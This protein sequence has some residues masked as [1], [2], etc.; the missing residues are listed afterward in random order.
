MSD[1][2][3]IA[4]TRMW[5]AVNLDFSKK[6]K[7][8]ID[9]L[10]DWAQLTSESPFSL[11]TN[12]LKGSLAKNNARSAKVAPNQLNWI[13]R[14][15]FSKA[16]LKISDRGGRVALEANEFDVSKIR[17]IKRNQTMLTELEKYRNHGNQKGLNYNEF[18][19]YTAATQLSQIFCKSLGS[20]FSKSSPSTID[21]HALNL[22]ISL[23]TLSPEAIAS[24]LQELVTLRYHG[25]YLF[26][27]LL[28]EIGQPPILKELDDFTGLCYK[29]LGELAG[30]IGHNKDYPVESLHELTSILDYGSFGR[31]LKIPPR[32]PDI[33]NILNVRNKNI[34]KGSKEYAILENLT[35]DIFNDVFANSKGITGDL[36]PAGMNETEESIQ[37]FDLAEKLA[38][39]LQDYLNDY[40][41]AVGRSQ[42]LRITTTD[43]KLQAELDDLVKVATEH[44]TSIRKAESLTKLIHCLIESPRIINEKNLD[45]AEGFDAEFMMKAQLETFEYQIMKDKSQKL[46][47]ALQP[48]SEDI[49]EIHEMLKEAISLMASASDAEGVLSRQ[50]SDSNSRYTSAQEGKQILAAINVAKSNLESSFTKILKNISKGN[51][52]SLKSVA[53]KINAIINE[54]RNTIDEKNADSIVTHSGANAALM[55]GL[56]QGGEQII[57][58]AMAKILNTHTDS[59]CRN[60]IRGLN[61]DLE[62]LEEFKRKT[63]GDIDLFIKDEHEYANDIAMFNS[64]NLLA[65][66]TGP[67]Q[68]RMLKQ[69]YNYIWGTKDQSIRVASKDRYHRPTSSTILLDVTGQGCGGKMGKGRGYASESGEALEQ[70]IRVKK[71]GQTITQVCIVHSFAGG[72]GSGMILPVLTK[73]KKLLPSAVVWVFSAGDVL[74]GKS[75]YGPENVTYIT[76]DVLQSHYN[77]LHHEPVTITTN[78]WAD[79]KNYVKRNYSS[80][81]DDW[82]AIQKVL[83][84]LPESD[85][86]TYVNNEISSARKHFI[87]ST[88]CTEMGFNIDGASPGKEESAKDNDG[89]CP[90]D[91]LPVGDRQ[92]EDFSKFV[93]DPGNYEDGLANFTQ[94]MKAAEDVG[95][96]AIKTADA[97]VDIFG[98]NMIKPD[99]DQL[100][101]ITNAGHLRYIAKGVKDAK[102]KDIKQMLQNFEITESQAMQSFKPLIT[103]GYE[104]SLTEE[105]KTRDDIQTSIANYANK[106]RV[107]HQTIYDMFERVKLNLVVSNDPLVKHVI[108]SNAHLDKAA[109]FYTSGPRYEIYNSTMI[110][111]FLNLVH[112]LVAP[113]DFDSENLTSTASSYEVMDLNDMKNRTKPSVSATMLSL[114]STNPLTNYVEYGTNLN[115]LYDET[116]GWKLFEALFLYENSPLKN[117]KQD[118]NFAT[119]K[120]PDV[121][122]LKAVYIHYLS[123]KHGLRIFSPI[124]V[125]D[126]LSKEKLEEDLLNIKQKSKLFYDD[127]KDKILNEVDREMLHPTNENITEETF[128]NMTMWVRLL[129]PKFFRQI[130]A[131]HSS[132]LANY[133]DEVTSE[134]QKDWDTFYD[135]PHRANSTNKVERENVISN[136][137]SEYSGNT[138]TKSEEQMSMFLGDLGIIDAS[139]IAAFPSALLY[140]YAPNL[141]QHQMKEKIKISVDLQNGEEEIHLN[142]D[143]E[144]QI[145]AENPNPI[146]QLAQESR[147]SPWWSFREQPGIETPYLWTWKVSGSEYLEIFNPQDEDT[148]TKAPIISVSRTFMKNMASIKIEVADRYPDFASMTLFDKLVMASSNQRDASNKRLDS[149]KPNFRYAREEL[150]IYASP[151]R[152]VD[153]EDEESIFLR[154]FLL[155]PE[156]LTFSQEALYNKNLSPGI[157]E[158]IV[159]KARDSEG[160][161]VMQYNETFNMA[162]FSSTL[163]QRIESLR[164]LRFDSI[165]ETPPITRR[166]LQWVKE[167]IGELDSFSS[168][169][170]TLEFN[171]KRFFDDM[172]ERFNKDSE[173]GYDSNKKEEDKFDLTQW[174]EIS[175]NLANLFSRLS[176]LVFAAQRQERFERGEMVPGSGVSYEFTGSI[177]AIRSVTDDY[178]AVINTSANLDVMQIKSSI[179]YF[180]GNFLRNPGIAGKAFVQRIETGPLAHLTLVSQ[181]SAVTEISTNYQKLIRKLEQNQFQ[182]ITGPCVHPYAFVR[183]ILWMHTFRN[184]WIHDSTNT[185]LDSLEITEEVI[186]EVIGKPKTI[187]TS[188]HSVMASGEMVG[189]TLPQNDRKMFEDVKLISKSIN[190]M[191]QS[192]LETRMRSQ[193]HVPDMILINYLRSLVEEDGTEES[194]SKLLEHG[195]ATVNKIYPPENWAKLIKNKIKTDGWNVS[196][197]N[198]NASPELTGPF[199]KPITRKQGQKA[200][201]WLAALTEWM[202]FA[203]EKSNNPKSDSTDSEE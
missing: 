68:A 7:V 101:Y 22:C 132:T 12:R 120:M 129:G 128:E 4:L 110:D 17:F 121:N 27:N 93:K 49:Q 11:R 157:S 187:E 126:S 201:A 54:Y 57:R 199:G 173:E 83:K 169:E 153:D 103:A 189:T 165:E 152:L 140:T 97:F 41:T 146:S 31:L 63:N 80:L 138:N 125:I 24:A 193:L 32:N 14:L 108:L 182:T 183:N 179:D 59:R 89:Y 190:E 106:M 134:W 15:P 104:V 168:E 135:N 154:T 170:S 55:I 40:Q 18:S 123:Q 73:I 51:Q 159:K 39:N 67:E 50:L 62:A 147:Q 115:G 23:E 76:S 75:K 42:H 52:P 78:E 34:R 53:N 81:R 5:L 90:A 122:A 37:W 116:V 3:S 171:P 197:E 77:A 198:K 43:N 144:A 102:D 163:H 136:L 19:F 28:A 91:Y 105:L 113:E 137:V 139:H 174:N 69:P 21:S 13:R 184:V 33:L 2:D 8:A 180:Y 109:N 86:K 6:E 160:Q 130:Y 111:V 88:T 133:F 35:F 127:F 26:R 61:I 202:A 9:N 72:S 155:H 47:E 145:F 87:E 92:S 149:E 181:Q 200:A 186:R 192:E 175:R 118:V 45:I 95:S 1:Q 203:S 124:E 20:D 164:D 100:H 172:F 44:M 142:Q 99:N 131:A 112:G 38:E 64:A 176:S 66:N 191:S 148:S 30:A 98:P 143:L 85:T 194:F 71:L 161:R 150:E 177:D 195:E 60:I 114:T 25:A 74:D 48:I 107:Y 166:V 151:R 65:I 119:S 70:A 156:N 82:K 167:E 196:K 185:Y 158:V 36:N 178:L 16:K 84:N 58:A 141:I 29:V 79:F 117:P 56:G 46:L 96:I 162:D 188:Q 10:A 94:W